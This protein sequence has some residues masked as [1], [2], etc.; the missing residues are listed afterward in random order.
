MENLSG[1]VIKNYEIRDRIGIGGF[2]SVYRA[3]QPIVDREVAI[4]IIL[5]QYANQAH[6]IRNFENEARLI[7]KLEHIHIVP[8]Y[9]FWRDPTGAYIVMRLLR[10]GSLQEMLKRDGPW[11][12]DKAATLLEQVA[13]ALTVAHRNGVVHQDIKAANILLDEDNNAYLTD[14]G[15]AKDLTQ[16]KMPNPDGVEEEV[17]HGSPEYMAPE[18]ILRSPVDAR[19][20]IYS[21]GV[22]LYEVLTGKKPFQSKDD[23]ELIRNQLYESLPPLQIHRPELPEMLNLVI[24]RATDKNPRRR[25]TT[26]MSMA[27]N[28]RQFSNLGRNGSDGAAVE[29]EKPQEADQDTGKDKASDNILNLAELLVE[30]VNPY[31]GLRAF[32]ETDAADFFGREKLIEQLFQRIRADT[33]QGTARFLAVVGP[34]GSG[35]SSVVKAGLIPQLRA[36]ADDWFIAEMTPGASPLQEV[37]AALFRAAHSTDIPIEATLRAD[38]DGLR[39][40]LPEVLGDVFREMVLVIDQFEEVFT[41]V[42]DE[43]ERRH[44]MDCLRQAL[45]AED[46]RLRVIVTLRADFYDRPLMYTGFGELMQKRTEVV[47]PMN[48]EELEDAI[49]KPAERAG[50]KLEEGLAQE[51]I[52]EVV[53]QPGTLPLLQYA[54]TELFANRRGNTLTSKS[55]RDSGGV[56]GSMTRRAD[57][58]FLMMNKDVRKVTEQ[59]F[60]R[61]VSLG[62]GTEDTRRRVTMSE[63]LSIEGD[64]RAIQQVLDTFGKRR[65]LAFDI[66]LKT[67]VPTVEIA[68]EALIRNWIQLRE[69]LTANRDTLRAQRQLASAMHEWVENNRDSSFLAIGVRLGQFETLLGNSSVALNADEQEY[70]TASMQRREREHLRRNLFIIGLIVIAVIASSLAIFAFT[71][72]A[73]AEEQRQIAENERQIA[74]SRELAITALTSRTQLDLA[75]LLSIES[76][77]TADTFEAR[78]TLLTLL[79]DGRSLSSTARID[80]YLHGHTGNVRTVAISPDGTRIATGAQDNT[81]RLWDA[82]AGKTVGEPL[83]GHQGWVNKVVF[84]PDGR[85]LASASHDDTI[86]LWDVATGQPVGTPLVGHTGHVWGIAFSSDGRLLASASEDDTVRLWDVAAGMPIGEP[87]IG[88]N[89][90]VLTV[91]FDIAGERLASGGADNM[92]RLWDVETHAPIGD[93]LAGHTDWVRAL[94]FS[95]DGRF[96]ASAGLDRVPRLWSARTSQSIPVSFAAVQGNI[97]DLTFDSTSRRLITVSED[98]RAVIF[99]ITTAQAVDILRLPDGS[100]MWGVAVQSDNTTLVIVSESRTPV[101][102][103]LDSAVRFGQVLPASDEM[104]LPITNAAISADGSRL[105]AFGND[106]NSRDSGNVLHEWSLNDLNAGET[107]RS[108]AQEPPRIVTASAFSPDKTVIVTGSVNGNLLFSRVDTGEAVGTPLKISD[109]QIRALAYSHTGTL[110]AVGLS[111][112][113]IVLLEKQGAADDTWQQTQR[114]FSGHLARV[115][116]LAFSPDDTLLASGSLDTTVRLWR[117][118]TGEALGEIDIS[119]NDDEGII[120]LAFS[121]DG[122]LLA[123]GGRD[124]NVTIWEVSSFKPLEVASAHT[125]WIQ[126]IAFAPDGKTLATASRDETLILWDVTDPA[127]LR[128]IGEPLV[129]HGSSVN[130]V[131]FSPDGKTLVSGAE[132]R[133]VIVW[134]MDVTEWVNAACHLAN[135][136]LTSDEWTR[137]L[138]TASY[139]PTCGL[140]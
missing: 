63:L 92:I 15:I 79:Q 96:L 129:G 36:H 13:S 111:N 11:E 6:F 119:Q 110:L 1:Q 72:R 20:D 24:Q 124:N 66:D 116:T 118:E 65:L 104:T 117:V 131:A 3:Y 35:K 71:Q 125:N 43:E 5:P 127:N 102:W 40:L 7:A 57:E 18:Q 109:D 123:S 53:G 4:K 8:L 113:Q 32:Q 12:V 55:Y 45:L 122:Q 34:S 56:S 70:L 41:M 48:A 135:R 47:L 81:I 62:E 90:D 26:P 17:L 30:P 10:G 108:I 105:I 130:T 44:F 27:E 114:T 51:I 39:Q 23:D 82:A 37:E 89:A 88:H 46:S 85:L 19:T 103:D 99:D 107:T 49:V 100:K 91:A 128:Q 94:A 86:R 68:H 60:L 21:L 67:R 76:F 137:F 77:R 50:L 78:D 132:N 64:K 29:A 140:Q 9:D 106:I 112:G 83:S 74:A 84:S 138:R 133:S 115:L 14:F 101:V 134:H 22:V 2:G 73:R 28:F 80:R 98:N 93:P 25:Y 59:V 120:S 95:P 58:I 126:A 139:H 31:K 52:A 121:P 69:W 33:A 61:L 136:D 38:V 97:R 54:L 75:A 87:L 16:A 42:T